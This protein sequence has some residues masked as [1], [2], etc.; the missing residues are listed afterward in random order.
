M[1][2]ATS[3]YAL[4]AVLVLAQAGGRTVR[5]DE[6]AAAIGAP[7][8]YLAKTL[9]ALAKHGVVTSARGPTGGFQLAIPASLLTVA[10]VVDC[11]D[12]PRRQTLCL[13]GNASCS[14][15]RPCAAHH[16]WTAIGQAQRAPLASTTIADLIG[17]SHSVIATTYPLEFA[18]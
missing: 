18:R 14:P 9:N 17:E 7:R 6:I 8:N 12:E 1:I 2:S 3:E 11:F 5:A 16:K 10:A 13:L 15:E 4:R